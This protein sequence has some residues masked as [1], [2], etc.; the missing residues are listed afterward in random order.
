[1]GV[2]QPG[3]G[4]FV[5]T[6]LTTPDPVTLHETFRQFVRQGLSAAAIEASSIGIE[7]RRLDA[8]RITVA[9]FTNFTQDH[10]DYHGSMAAYW[11]AKR[12]LF[13]WP[14]LK[15]AVIN[16][17]DEQGLA[18][19]PHVQAR[20]VAVWSYSTQA[21]AR[22]QVIE[23]RG[24]VDG[25]DVLVAEHDASLSQVL[26]QVRIQAPLIGQFNVSNLLAVLGAL[27][28]LGVDLPD[29]A[30]ACAHLS[31]VPGRMQAVRLL[32]EDPLAL[33]L[34]VVDYAHTPDA[35]H[36]ALLA[37]RPIT[38]ARGGR[39][40][41]VFGCGGNR[42]PLKR[43]LMGAVADQH[44]DEVVLTSDNPRGEQ[45]ADI[46]AQIRAGVVR[47]QALAVI[48][49]RREAIAHALAQADACDVV[50]IAGKGH[51]QTQEIAGIK[52]PFSDIDETMNA[53]SERRAA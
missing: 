24:A 38:Q 2:G 3:S 10:L 21:P 15:A 27:R 12:A 19:V 25:M 52:T 46:L 5:P 6:G 11:L 37:L 41:C 49:G 20:G 17:D 47:P 1:L 34:A 26:G 53:L 40:W 33:P 48:E 18:L 22:L 45:P 35:L 42:D 9:Q 51:E 28:A 23:S 14:G 4:E 31:A 50:L 39:L 36:K 13:D 30:T 44:A 29:A 16:V 7:E 8:T 32:G 43:P